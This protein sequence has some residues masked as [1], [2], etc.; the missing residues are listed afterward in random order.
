MRVSSVRRSGKNKGK[1]RSEL[2]AR[3]L[4]TRCGK[5][6]LV[7]KATLSRRSLSM[8]KECSF[9]KTREDALMR[10]WGKVPDG[11]DMY[12]RRKWQAIKF[13]CEDPTSRHWFRYG[14]RGIKLSDEFQDPRIFVEHVR[15]LPGASRN[16]QIDRIDNSKGYERGNLRWVDNRTNCNNR[17]CTIAV[18]YNGTDIPLS[19]FVRD[20]TCL[21]YTY[22]KKLI[23]Q[24]KSAKEIIAWR[25]NKKDIIYK[26][27]SMSL[28]QFAMKYTDMTPANVGKLYRS[29]MSPEDIVKW[30]KH[31]PRKICYEGKAITFPEFVRSYTNLSLAYAEKLYREGVSVERLTEWR[32]KSDVVTYKGQEMHFKDFV[33]DHTGMSYVYA[34]QMY[35]KGKSLDEIAGWKRSRPRSGI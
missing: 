27:E 15:S 5:E 14:G 30:K 12:L 18:R 17:D 16:L 25:K 34:R 20:Y 26:G 31:E 9:K 32:K 1:A 33:R 8:C 29:G 24:G 23:D 4:C 2:Y 11:F 13:R 10:S 22:V 35:R 28:R 3:F 7:N 19:D 21:S 6:I